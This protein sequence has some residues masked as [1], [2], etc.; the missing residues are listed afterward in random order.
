MK[1]KDFINM[2]QNCDPESDLMF[3]YK[4]DKDERKAVAFAVLDSFVHKKGENKDAEAMFDCMQVCNV[5]TD[6]YPNIGDSNCY[7]YLEQ[8]YYT[9]KAITDLIQDSK[10]Y[11]IKIQPLPF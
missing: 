4:E 5:K 2:L 9:D 7:V 10:G 11:V 1:V 8:C 3:R 6:Y